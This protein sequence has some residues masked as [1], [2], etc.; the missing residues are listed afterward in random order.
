M[1]LPQQIPRHRVT[2][3]LVPQ[4]RIPR[5][6]ESPRHPACRIMQHHLFIP[7][8]LDEFICMFDCELHIWTK[9]SRSTYAELDNC[10]SVMWYEVGKVRVSPPPLSLRA[11][12]TRR[13]RVRNKEEGRETKKESGNEALILPPHTTLQNDNFQLL[14]TQI[15]CIWSKQLT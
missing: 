14:Q 11:T 12:L 13:V 5:T 15:F 6:C 8:Q 1:Q 3:I 7:Q 2:N 4:S 10:H 9:C